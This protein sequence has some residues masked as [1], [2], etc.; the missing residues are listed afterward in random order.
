VLLDRTDELHVAPWLAAGAPLV[1]LV[2]F[3]ASVRFWH[4]Q[5]RHYASTGS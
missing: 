2:L 5:T 4:H 3:A 1:G